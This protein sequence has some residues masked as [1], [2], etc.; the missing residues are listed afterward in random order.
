MLVNDKILFKLIAAAVVEEERGEGG[1]RE[2]KG[3]SRSDGLGWVV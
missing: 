1:E 2:E 3:I